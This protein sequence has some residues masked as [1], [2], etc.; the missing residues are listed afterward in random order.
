MAIVGVLQ[1]DDP[2]RRGVNDFD[3]VFAVGRDHLQH[4]ILA[5]LLGVCLLRL[6]LQARQAGTIG[7][8]GNVAL[9]VRIDLRSEAV[10]IVGI[11]SGGCGWSDRSAVAGSGGRLGGINRW[12]GGI[13]GSRIRLAGLGRLAAALSALPA[14]GAAATASARAGL[15]VRAGAVISVSRRLRSRIV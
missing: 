13:G 1:A 10:R 11:G 2:I 14:A 12:L 9:G 7:P 5:R 3:I 4:L 15:A 6:H 8:P